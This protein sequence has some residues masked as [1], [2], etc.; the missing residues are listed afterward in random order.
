[1]KVR[2]IFKDMAPPSEGELASILSKLDWSYEFSDSEYVQ[3]K[4]QKMM[5]HAENMMYSFYKR[6]PT[7]ALS[8]WKKF[9]PYAKNLSE[10]IEPDFIV[11]FKLVDEA[12]SK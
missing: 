9:C 3:R 10:D 5:E 8:L 4:G 1:M 7:K 6:N 2:E 11:R 12:D